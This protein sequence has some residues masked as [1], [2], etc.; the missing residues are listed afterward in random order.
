MPAAVANPNE[1][2]IKFI[3][4]LRSKLK[5]LEQSL[6]EGE[7]VD[8]SGCGGSAGIIGQQPDGSWRI[9]VEMHLK[10]TTLTTTE[11]GATAN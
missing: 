8:C 2:T 5:L 11:I 3:Q 6:E 1:P 4:H 9:D 10:P 7:L